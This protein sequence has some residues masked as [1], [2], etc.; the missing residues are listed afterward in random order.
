VRRNPGTPS[1]V[2]AAPID[3]LLVVTNRE[4]NASRGTR[5]RETYPAGTLEYPDADA[6]RYLSLDRVYVLS[7]DDFER[8]VAGIKQDRLH[9]PTLLSQCVEADR[10]PESMKFLFHQ[11]LDALRIKHGRSQLIDDALDAV[12]ARF[13]AQAARPG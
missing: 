4:L 10:A 1:Q 6:Q 5:L 12:V 8:V 13:E 9:L 11:H 7:V 2:R 3:Y